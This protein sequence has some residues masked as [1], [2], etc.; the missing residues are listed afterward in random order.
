MADVVIQITL[1]FTELTSAN[2]I[3]AFQRAFPKLAGETNANYAKRFVREK[4]Q[5]TITEGYI[6]LKQ[7]AIPGQI[8]VIGLT[9]T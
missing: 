8:P 2:D 3:A 9:V 5:D 7:D 6:K 4:A 1:T